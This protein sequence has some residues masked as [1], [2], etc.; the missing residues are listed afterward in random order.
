MEEKKLI[1]ATEFAVKHGIDGGRVRVL[2]RD[3]RIEGAF[4][5][6]NQWVIPADAPK[7]PDLRVKSGKYRGW[8][9]KY[10]GKKKQEG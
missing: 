6:G 4:K 9:K 8:R 5:V 2:L 10:P 7:P 1:S 3:G